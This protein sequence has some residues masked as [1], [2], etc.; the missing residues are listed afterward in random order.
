[1]NKAIIVIGLALLYVV[2][3]YSFTYNVF[4]GEIFP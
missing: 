1:M 4:G 2:A 3:V